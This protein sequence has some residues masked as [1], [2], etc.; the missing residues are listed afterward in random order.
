MDHEVELDILQY[1]ADSYPKNVIILL[2]ITEFNLTKTT[3]PQHACVNISFSACYL[4]DGSG[5]E[6]RASD[7]TPSAPAVKSGVARAAATSRVYS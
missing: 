6:S 1:S 2:F 3:K 7:E 5:H 4:T